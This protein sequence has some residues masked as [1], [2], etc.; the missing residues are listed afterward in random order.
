LAEQLLRDEA[1]TTIV[2]F[3]AESHVDRSIYGPGAFIDTNVVGT[4]VLLTAACKVWL[5]EGRNG[6]A[7]RFHQVSMDEVYGS[8]GPDDPPF[9]GRTPFAP[10]SPYAASKAGADHLVR[11]CHQ[12]YGLP[13]TTTNCS[14][15]FGPYQFP[16]KLIP[17]MLVHLLEG[18]PLPVYGD[19][20]NVRD[21][22]YVV[23]H[24]RAVELTLLAGTVG[25][26]YNVGGGWASTNLDTVTLLCRLVDEAFSGDDRLAA[27]FPDA[28]AAR[29]R[30]S[31]SLI[32]FVKGRPGHDRRYAIDGRA[33]ES[34]LGFRPA[35]SFEGRLR[36]TVTWY[37]AHEGWSR[38][39]MDGSY[40]EWMH[41]HY[42]HGGRSARDA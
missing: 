17:L 36:Q 28:P 6:A 19:G 7:V 14:N 8:L 20:L 4:H 35:Q 25:E 12:T 24:C 22:L 42:Q 21:W 41:L 32:R 39:V 30:A 2:H 16:E 33:I 38:G 15:H 31:S 40:R 10:N 3:A 5:D 18:K 26:T 11:A 27:R 23:D 9:T 34:A 29:A 37:L 13:V 1:I